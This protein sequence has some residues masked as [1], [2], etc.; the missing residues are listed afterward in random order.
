MAEPQSFSIELIWKEE[1]WKEAV[2]TQSKLDWEEENAEQLI[3]KKEVLRGK[4]MVC[5]KSVAKTAKSPT[6]SERS[7]TSADQNTQPVVDSQHE[8]VR[9]LTETLEK[10]LERFIRKNSDAFKDARRGHGKTSKLKHFLG[11]HVETMSQIALLAGEAASFAFAPASAITVAFAHLLG[12]VA[13]V[14]KWNN[15]IED[16]FNIMDSFVQRLMIIQKLKAINT[17]KYR[18]IVAKVFAGMLR[19]C[20]DVRKRMKNRSFISDGFKALFGQDGGLQDSYDRVV[21]SIAELDS[22]TTF[23]ALAALDGLTRK[24]DQTKALVKKGVETIVDRLDR[25]NVIVTSL[26]SRSRQ[27]LHRDERAQARQPRASPFRRGPDSESKSPKFASLAKATNSLATGAERHVLRHLQ[28]MHKVFVKDTF[29]WFY[30]SVG[31]YSKLVDEHACRRLSIF[32]KPGTGKS[33][34]AFSLFARLTADFESSK[35]T[36]VVFFV[37]DKDLEG[38]NTVKNMMFCCAMQLTSTDKTYCKELQEAFDDKPNWK[39]DGI[40][41][42]W[43]L[44]FGRAFSRRKSK[45]SLFVVLDGTDQLTDIEQ[46]RLEWSLGRF[47]GDRVRVQVATT[48]NIPEAEPIEGEPR[49]RVVIRDIGMSSINLSLR[50][51]T[52]RISRSLSPPSARSLVSAVQ[53]TGGMN[54]R[55]NGLLKAALHK[56]FVVN[57]DPDR[58]KNDIRLLTEEMMRGDTTFKNLSALESG[59]QNSIVECVVRKADNFLYIN[60]ALRGFN[61]IKSRSYMEKA[62]KT[63]PSG[64][65]QVYARLVEQCAKNLEIPILKTLRYFLA[66]M[67][68]SPE[69]QVSGPAAE[70]LFGVISSV[71]LF[72][73]PPLDIEE[74]AVEG[75]LSR[76]LTVYDTETTVETPIP[77]NGT[78]GAKGVTST[79]IAFQEHLL[80][81]YFRN[82]EQMKQGDDKVSTLRVPGAKT[83]TVLLHIANGILLK[84]GTN[85]EVALEELRYPT[86]NHWLE[87]LNGFLDKNQALAI[88]KRSPDSN[89]TDTRDAEKVFVS[90]YKIV[91]P[92]QRRNRILREFEDRCGD[93]GDFWCILGT[94]PDLARQTLRKLDLFASWVAKRKP[95][96]ILT[97]AAIAWASKIVDKAK[98]SPILESLGSG[99]VR[100]W[101][102]AKTARAAYRS[103]WLA[104]STFSLL[105]DKPPPTAGAIDVWKE[106]LKSWGPKNQKADKQASMAFFYCGRD[107]DAL[108]IAKDALQDLPT[109]HAGRRKADLQYRAARAYFQMWQNDVRDAARLAKDTRESL[110]ETISSMKMAMSQDN[111]GN[112]IPE[113]EAPQTAADEEMT[114]TISLAFQMTARMQIAEASAGERAKA[115]TSMEEAHRWTSEPGTHLRFFNDLVEKFGENKEWPEIILLLRQFDKY[116]DPAKLLHNPL[117]EQCSVRAH[118]FIAEA[119]KAASQSDQKTVRQLYKL[120]AN[121]SPLLSTRIEFASFL[122]FVNKP[123]LAIGELQTV[124]DTPGLSDFVVVEQASNALADL[125]FRTFRISQDPKEKHSVLDQTEAIA[126]RLQDNHG[127]EF[128]RNMSEISVPLALMKRKLGPRRDFTRCMDDSFRACIKALTDNRESNDRPSLRLLS[129]LLAMAPSTTL[130]QDARIAMSCQFYRCTVT[131]TDIE[132]TDQ[133]DNEYDLNGSQSF[134]ASCLR[135]INFPKSRVFTCVSCISRDLCSTCRINKGDRC[136]THD[137]IQAPAD[138]WK[139]VRKGRVRVGKEPKVS[140]Q[141]FTKW[142]KGLESKWDE[143]WRNYWKGF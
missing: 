81:A 117:G 22:A 123:K 135:A 16:L 8:A 111:N 12:A 41:A 80:R 91:S 69:G 74:E 88:F 143:A 30:D 57:L 87:H 99:H 20:V 90:L 48:T 127:I 50:G 124:L 27:D 130:N 138:N 115:V 79:C 59:L 45:R 132:Q 23:Q 36:S 58:I 134:C 102:N 5:F 100:N 65:Q 11:R 104:S 77:T 86:F 4:V 34:L 70:I 43:D 19:F 110:D 53:S 46:D 56:P 95:S 35:T 37:F 107:E 84:D 139:G 92:S 17:E 94:T 2:K 72:T 121:Q 76:I 55:S 78:L 101:L 119:T 38:L 73:S 108:K 82:P 15:L 142:V 114:Y 25:I 137:A 63:P 116:G 98:P 68:H 140:D 13:T 85:N 61:A 52:S 1:V 96:G 62:L 51:T 21:S 126:Q 49:G 44:L 136:A 24:S 141:E 40:E 31:Y 83:H 112:T 66:W 7:P 14:S 29:A 89:D 118:R 93:D 18:P 106:V 9:D 42:Q 39:D 128:N 3:K 6:T 60:H 120:A 32:G 103:L 109:V 129:K 105:A 131:D 28:Q 122:R 133:P 97:A 125:L 47:A 67:A 33:F 10:D 64:I 54:N 26:D 75:K 113:A 71:M